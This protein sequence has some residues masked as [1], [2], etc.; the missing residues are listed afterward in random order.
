MT[1]AHYLQDFAVRV[2][3]E[4]GRAHRG[5]AHLAPHVSNDGVLRLQRPQPS[6]HV[7]ARVLAGSACQTCV[8]VRSVFSARRKRIHTRTCVEVDGCVRISVSV[9]PS[10]SLSE[11]RCLY[12]PRYLGTCDHTA[13]LIPIN[14][15]YRYLSILDEM[16]PFYYLH[17]CQRRD[18]P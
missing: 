11:V 15:I 4:R 12:V 18:G 6:Q 9:S 1:P 14:N 2:Y 3:G 10:L 5:R 16:L 17:V 7:V 8:C 13:Y